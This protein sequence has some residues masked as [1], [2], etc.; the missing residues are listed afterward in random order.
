MNKTIKLFAVANLIAIFNCLGQ[1]GNVFPEVSNSI[2]YEIGTLKDGY[3]EGIWE[4][5]DIPG[6]LS[7]KVNYDNGQLLYL[8]PD[9]SDYAIQING[10]WFNSKVDMQP[11]YVGSMVEFYNILYANIRYPDEAKSNSTVGQ[12]YISFEIDTL[13]HANN[14]NTINDI[15]DKCSAEIIRALQLIPN[16]WLSATKK[17]RKYVAKF[18]LPISFK[19]ELDGKEIKEEK[20]KNNTEIVLPLAKVLETIEIKAA[21]FTR[22]N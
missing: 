7:L 5:Y 16:I 15:G 14:Y 18:I 4:Y 12:F 22:R 8:I 20:R 2:N 11:R 9:T 13:G 6:E 17:D 10:E 3:K 21:G 1:P 19:M